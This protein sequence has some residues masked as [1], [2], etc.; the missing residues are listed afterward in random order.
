V[1]DL[2]SGLAPV[3]L[4]TWTNVRGIDLLESLPEVDRSRIGCTGASGGGQQ[5]MYLMAME[6][7]VKAAVPAVMITYF[8]KILSIGEDAHC[9]CNHLPGIVAEADETEMVAAFAPRPALYLCNTTDWTKSF[10]WDELPDVLHAYARYG[11]ESAVRY[12]QHV[13]EHDYDREMRELAY[14]FFER[15]LRG[16]TDLPRDAVPEPPLRAEDP[17]ALEALAAPPPGLVDQRG[18]VAWAR[19]RAE[20]LRGA[21]S[22]G[23]RRAAVARLAGH[24]ASAGRTARGPEPVAGGVLGEGF[25]RALVETE[26]GVRLPVV[27]RPPA[28]RGARI[29]ILAH[30]DGKLGALAEMAEEIDGALERGEGVVCADVRLRGELR[31]DWTWNGVAWRRPEAG[32]AADDLAALGRWARAA[33]PGSPVEAVAAGDLALAGVLAA[34]LDDGAEPALDRVRV[35]ALPPP[36]AESPGTLLPGILAAAEIDDLARLAGKRLSVD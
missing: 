22:D 30:P 18:A 36:F 12:V 23:E 28:R 8:D 10:P 32:M 16:R 15:T 34:V 13:K 24:V 1:N 2:A 33:W 35:N 29:A 14:G 11:A 7:R 31:R 3:G 20:R 4:M 9:F 27:V 21:L 25:S 6:D 19:E 26:P 17:R 5:T